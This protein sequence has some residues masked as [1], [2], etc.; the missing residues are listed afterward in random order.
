MMEMSHSKMVNFFLE[1]EDQ[2]EG[3]ASLRPLSLME[4]RCVVVL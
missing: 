3:L 4:Q 1:W 2:I